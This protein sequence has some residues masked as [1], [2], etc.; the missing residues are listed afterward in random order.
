MNDIMRYMQFFKFF[1]EKVFLSIYQS[2]EFHKKSRIS[3][4]I[5][6]FL[7]NGLLVVVIIFKF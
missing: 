2:I 3:I 6:F 5:E 7:S 1:Y 4:I